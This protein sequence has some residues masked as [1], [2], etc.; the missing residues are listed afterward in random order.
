MRFV[1]QLFVGFVL[2]FWIGGAAAGE[3]KQNLGP[4]HMALKG[5]D[6]VSY[7]TQ[8][9]AIPGSAEFSAEFDG[10]TYRFAS[11]S[12][13]DAFRANPALYVPAFGGYCA[14]G[15][16]FGQKIDVDPRAF[17]VVD[18]RL[19]LNLNS[20]VQ[21]RWLQD[22]PGNLARANRHWSTIAGQPP[23]AGR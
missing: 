6:P 7:Q 11:A 13:R 8:N 18:G 4:G 3:G 17:R 15:M 5:Y 22:V 19:Y 12:N 1:G 10:A 20:D 21:A 2:V 14:M 23:A 16:A 9:A